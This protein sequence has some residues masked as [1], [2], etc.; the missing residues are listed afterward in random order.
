[1]T[2]HPVGQEGHCFLVI[3]FLCSA[4]IHYALPVNSRLTNSRKMSSL[5][6]IVRFQPC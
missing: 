6:A 5:S 1:M 2:S 4:F 3:N